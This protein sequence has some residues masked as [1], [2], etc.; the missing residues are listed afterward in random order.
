[1]IVRKT[2]SGSA[3]GTTI[4]ARSSRRAGTRDATSSASPSPL[5]S[6]SAT[7]SAGRT[8]FPTRACQKSASCQS[9][10]KFSRLGK[11]PVGASVNA[12]FSA[13]AVGYAR[14]S[15]RYAS[16]GAARNHRRDRPATISGSRARQ[17]ARGS[18]QGRFRIRVLEHDGTERPLPEP[19]QLGV[20]RPGRAWPDVVLHRGEPLEER[21][22]SDADVAPCREPP[23]LPGEPRL[24]V[25]TEQVADERAGSVGVRR[26]SRNAEVAAAEYGRSSRRPGWERRRADG[27][28]RESLARVERHGER[29]VELEDDLAARHRLGD[30]RLLPGRAVRVEVRRELGEETERR[31]RARVVEHVA[32][33]AGRPDE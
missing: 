9:T 33:A 23:E 20:V 6:S 14:K 18:P 25:A 21:A 22:R 1:M 2:I 4:T 7:V 11:P 24:R 28:G 31:E 16:S 26:V 17:L 29:P 27:V 3:N 8:T 15:A 32:P 19:A 30:R 13:D 12:S 10:R 5:T